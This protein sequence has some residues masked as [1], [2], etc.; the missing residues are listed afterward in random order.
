MPGHN[1]VVA[2]RAQLRVHLKGAGA[3]VQT[4]GFGDERQ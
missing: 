4:P 1:G 2:L 3:L